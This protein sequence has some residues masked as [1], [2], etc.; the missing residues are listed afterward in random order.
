MPPR[1]GC[2]PLHNDLLS[3]DQRTAA[4]TQQTAPN[5]ATPICSYHVL[6]IRRA[7]KTACSF[8]RYNRKHE[9]KCPLAWCFRYWSCKRIQKRHRN[10]MHV[11]YYRCA[12]CSIAICKSQGIHFPHHL[13]RLYIQRSGHQFSQRLSNRERIFVP[14]IDIPQLGHRTGCKGS[15]RQSPSHGGQNHD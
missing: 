11:D 7:A 13:Q 6:H 9:S 5:I 8:S 1:L 3:V 4:N 12:R 10:G 15:Q 2:S 14:T